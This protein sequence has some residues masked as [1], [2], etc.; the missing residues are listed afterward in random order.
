MKTVRAKLLTTVFSGL[1]L[2]LMSAMFAINSVK[3]I[4]QEYDVL[5]QEELSAQL[6][7]NLILNTFKTQV[8]EWKNILIRGENPEQ[9]DKYFK[10][11]EE[12][13]AFVQKST[14]ELMSGS[15]LPKSI[16]MQ[17]NSFK[18][19]HKKLGELYRIGLSEF[20]NAN[21]NTQDGDKAVKGIDR[22][23]AKHLKELNQ[24]IDQYVES[25]VSRL[26]AEKEVAIFESTVITLTVSFIVIVTMALLIQHWITRPIK[27]ASQVATEISN[28]N[29]ENRISSTSKDEIGALLTSLDKMQTNIRQANEQLT[30]Q[31]LQQKLQAEESGRIKQA[32]DN[33]SS[34][35][36]LYKETNE[37]IYAN[38]QTNELFNRYQSLINSPP[39][40]TGANII[41]ILSSDYEEHLKQAKT[42]QVQFEMNIDHVYMNITASPVLNDEN[43][44]IG[45]VVELIDLTE[46]RNTENKVDDIINSAVSGQLDARL[47]VHN[48]NGFMLTLSKGINRLL[49]AIVSPVQ[50]TEKYLTAISRGEIPDKIEGN[51]SGD[52]LKI[53]QSLEQSSKA[54]NL[55]I[56]DSKFLVDSALAGQLSH[57]AD[58]DAHNGEF[59]SIITGINQTL[60]A[61]IQPVQLTSQYL[62]SI[63]IG[64][65][66]SVDKTQFN[67]DFE[68][69]LTSFE[70]SIQAINLL[71][72]DTSMLASAANSGELS[73]RANI[74]LHQGA[75]KVI[76]SSINDTLDAIS[77]PLQSCIA[78][79]NALEHGDLTKKIEGNYSGDFANLKDSVNQSIENLASMVTEINDTANTVA[80][81]SAQISQSTQDL[82]SSTESQAASIEETTV[83]MGEVTDKVTSN[84]KHA[85]TANEHAQNADKQ[86][87]EGGTLVNNTVI[88][89]KA[90]SDS[91]NEISNIIEVINGIAFQTNLLALNA[92]VEAARAGEKGRG[93]AVVAAEVRQLA[94]RSSD[95]AKEISGLLKDSADKVDNGLMLAEQS[96]N[97]LRDI[98]SSIQTLSKLMNDIALSSN[99]QS[100]GVSQINI[101]IKQIDQSVQQNNSLVEQTSHAGASLDKQASH[102]RALVSQFTV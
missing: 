95:A 74:E 102:L 1:A 83:S 70:T 58:S 90:I 86:A 99:E 65:I 73:K 53:K 39:K 17:L 79:M 29:L 26:R 89:M 52:F 61:I 68:K 63:A 92:A 42:K 8:Q 51:Y 33:A 20:K 56:S 60:D 87:I 21:Y 23:A 69:I 9:F 57:R 3:Y 66:P 31:M 30:Q 25:A 82:N 22:A 96:G 36:L 85:Q 45:V 71:L 7:V 55:L 94:Q 75:Y 24:S 48:L 37:I 27:L 43:N 62:D 44:V 64:Q 13:E 18:G 84:T 4:T 28:G 11:F 19:E 14:S 38:N 80:K 81:A 10:Q 35:V 91:S 54:I 34:P 77:T 72:N 15:Y 97:T 98:V 67:G 40:L 100:N 76:V 78:V 88:A 12:Q 49:D 32:L 6:K 46:Q 2:V 50:Q 93:F 59:K 101:A 16:L 47:D 5:I 41:Q